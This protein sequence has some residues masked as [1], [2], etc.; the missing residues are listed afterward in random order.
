[1]K[2]K[3]LMIMINGFYGANNSGDEAMLRNFVY[4]IRKRIPDCGIIVATDKRQSFKYQDLYWVSSEDRSQ[5]EN[6]DVFVSGGGDLSP[7]F[8]NQLLIHAKKTDNKLIMMGVSINSNWLDEKLREINI[9][10]LRLF[11]K[12][13]VRDKPS[14]ENLKLLGVNAELGTDM[15]IDLPFLPIYFKNS[16][17]HICLCVREVRQEYQ[18]V[19]TAKAEEVCRLFLREG[20]TISLLPLCKEDKE[21]YKHLVTLDKRNIEIVYTLNPEQHKHVILNS[22]YLVSLGRLHPLI[23]ATSIGKPFLAVSYPPKSNCYNK[24]YAWMETIG[25][26]FILD[27]NCKIDEFKN[28]WDN[29]KMR[30]A[31]VSGHLWSQGTYHKGLNKGQFDKM[32][33]V[34]NA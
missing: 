9:E 1:M 20:Y 11:D 26:S 10:T 13:F 27:F 3:R 18:P 32:V 33:E 21:H 2:G 31:E 6:T 24:M 15:A 8:G 29:L 23:Y 7:G 30:K 14:L 4:Q 12:V 34:I 25:C 16:E 28:K 5:L 22:D 17:K 19:Q